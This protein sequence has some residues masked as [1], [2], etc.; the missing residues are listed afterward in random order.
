MTASFT[1]VNNNF[2]PLRHVTAEIALGNLFTGD[3]RNGS[4]MKPEYATLGPR[5][6][7]PEW[8]DHTLNMDDRFTITPSD[9]FS[10]AKHAEIAIVVIYQPWIIPLQREKTFRFVT[11]TQSNG[12]L[13][14]YSQPSN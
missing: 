10:R 6:V 5:L 14:W 8:K 13:S 11:H 7:R 12:T 2:V 1:I 9:L 4:Y 3:D